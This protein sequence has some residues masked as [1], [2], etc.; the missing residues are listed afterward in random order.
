MAIR[1]T[2]LLV[3]FLASQNSF[4]AEVGKVFDG[5]AA[6][7][8]P[9]ESAKPIAPETAVTANLNGQSLTVA[10]N[11]CENG[12]WTIDTSM[13]VHRY[14]APNGQAVEL[15]FANFRLFVATANWAKHKFIELKG[16]ESNPETTIALTELDLGTESVDFSLVADKTTIVDGVVIDVSSTHWGAFRLTH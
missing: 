6:Y 10:L 13:P 2:A 15:R 5:R 11:I 14:V 1:L 12:K 4:A 9:L 7:C 3:L 8:P 16:F